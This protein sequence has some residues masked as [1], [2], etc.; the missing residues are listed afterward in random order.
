MVGMAQA[1][2]VAVAVAVAAFAER[3]DVV[4]LG[5]HQA[6]ALRLADR[7]S[8]Q[9]VAPH[10]V[11]ACGVAWVGGP[12]PGRTAWAGLAGGCELPASCAGAGC[13]VGQSG[14]LRQGVRRLVRRPA[15]TPAVAAWVEGCRSSVDTASV[16]GRIR[17]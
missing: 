12:F 7:V 9:L 10:L 1:G 16:L 15:T 4:D 14:F 8:A 17:R 6:A 13:G 3:Y 11:P 5:G 2:Q